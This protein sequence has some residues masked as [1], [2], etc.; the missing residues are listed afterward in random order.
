[1][2]DEVTQENWKNCKK[3]WDATGTSQSVRSSRHESLKDEQLFV[4]GK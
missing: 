3:L 4:Q 1:M 2:R